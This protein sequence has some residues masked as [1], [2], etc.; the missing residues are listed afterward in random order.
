[1]E[2]VALVVGH[3]ERSK[4]AYSATLGQ[5]EY[6]YYRDVCNIIS[7]IDKDIDVYLRKHSTGYIHEMIP[8]INELNARDYAFV[9]ELHFNAATDKKVRG[10][11]VLVYKNSKRGKE[12]GK[13]FLDKVQGVFNIPKRGFVEI[14]HQY[15]RGGYGICNTKAPYVLLE[16]FFGTNDKDSEAFK[17]RQDVAEFIVE[18]IRG[19]LC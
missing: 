5:Y 4:G 7:E 8:V 10:C 11:E 13:A 12:L 16:P 15:E 2:K 18:F 17:N 19:Q 1:M 9:L 3:N 6:D 14:E